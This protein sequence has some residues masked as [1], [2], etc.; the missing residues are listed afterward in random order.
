MSRAIRWYGPDIGRPPPPDMLATARLEWG[1][2]LSTFHGRH[3]D[4]HDA[5]LDSDGEI[6]G[7]Y[8]PAMTRSGVRFGPIY[9]A[10][11]RRGEGHAARVYREWATTHR[12]MVYVEDGNV[13]SAAA[14]LAAGLRPAHRGAAGRFYVGGVDHDAAR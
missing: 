13:R 3:M 6:V 8:T 10:P 7:F 2:R 14:A 1:L 4:R 5:I 9:V 11:E 12:V